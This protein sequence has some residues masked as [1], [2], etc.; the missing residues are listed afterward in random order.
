VVISN[1]E[2]GEERREMIRDEKRLVFQEDLNFFS[3]FSN[4]YVATFSSSVEF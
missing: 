3:S 1:E 2:S 4:N